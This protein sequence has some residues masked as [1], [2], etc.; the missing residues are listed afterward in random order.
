MSAPAGRAPS[1]VL[2]GRGLEALVQGDRQRHQV[3][4]HAADVT[5]ALWLGFSV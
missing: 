4:P 1:H 5:S 2:V 3:S